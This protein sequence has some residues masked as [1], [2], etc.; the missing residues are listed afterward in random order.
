MA[1]RLD[2]VNGVGRVGRL[3]QQGRCERGFVI[4]FKFA[5]AQVGLGSELML[6]ERLPALVDRVQVGDG[7]RRHG[8]VLGGVPQ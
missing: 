2:Q 1:G 6:G 4:D 5:Q 7:R 8:Q 3:G